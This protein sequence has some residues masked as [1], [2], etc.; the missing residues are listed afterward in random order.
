MEHYAELAA[1][2]EETSFLLSRLCASNEWAEAFKRFSKQKKSVEMLLFSNQLD[3]PPLA[4]AIERF[5]KVV[6]QTNVASGAMAQGLERERELFVDAIRDSIRRSELVPI[7]P[8]LLVSG[9]GAEKELAQLRAKVQLLEQDVYSVATRSWL[10]IVEASEL[11]AADPTGLSDPYCTIKN[12]K[13]VKGNKIETQVCPETL[14]PVWD[15]SFELDLSQKF[16]FNVEIFDWSKDR[17]PQ[18]L[19]Y[20]E[21][22]WS[23]WALGVRE[24]RRWLP[25]EDGSGT[26][27]I[28]L[29]AADFGEDKLEPH[30]MMECNCC[31]AFAKIEAFAC[32]VCTKAT[33]A[34][35]L[36]EKKCHRCSKNAGPDGC[37]RAKLLASHKRV[38]SQRGTI[39]ELVAKAK[40]HA[41][42]PDPKEWPIVRYTWP[43]W[44][45]DVA[46]LEGVA[47][48]Q[49]FSLTRSYVYE[50]PGKE[51][52]VSLE[53]LDPYE[54][55][56]HFTRHLIKVDVFIFI[57]ICEN[58]K[59]V[60]VV[61]ERLCEVTQTVLALVYSPE[62]VFRR[63][64]KVSASFDEKKKGGFPRPMSGMRKS[65]ADTM[66]TDNPHDVRAFLAESSFPGLAL[67]RVPWSAHQEL[68]ASLL[69][70][71]RN[72][73]DLRRR[74]GVLFVP[75]G[76]TDE[77]EMFKSS[78]TADLTEFLE[79]LG[80]RVPMLGWPKYAGGL[81]IKEDS[82]G[83][84]SVYTQFLG[85]EI[86]FHVNCLLLDDGSE[87]QLARKRYIGN[88]LVVFIFMENPND[89]FDPAVITSQMCHVFIVIRKTS[90][91][92]EPTKY[93]INV[94]A[95][96]GVPSFSPDLPAPNIL[97]KG[98]ACRNFLLAKA[99]N[100]NR[101]TFRAKTF[102]QKTRKTRQD[103]L[104]RMHKDL[105]TDGALQEPPTPVAD[106]TA[107]ALSTENRLFKTKVEH[108]SE[109]TGQLNFGQNEQI[110]A[111]SANPE[112]GFWT[113][114]LRDKIGRFPAEKVEPLDNKK[115]K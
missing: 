33:C 100:G 79:M 34:L 24:E 84:H 102:S 23:E 63:S 38:A 55:Y 22:N 113:G 53:M 8:L 66:R 62:G 16:R 13:D 67:N 54:T 71:E 48:E 49:G 92:D 106:L 2:M 60:V 81:N 89:V 78:E 11:G 17:I 45:S 26:V 36:W 44:T 108:T 21:I 70:F 90:V 112:E 94:V 5:G 87:Q 97:L 10:R 35:C 52:Y 32:E 91:G 85:F 64:L 56:D 40:L 42:M 98:E 20:V 77:N 6:S 72:H 57:G 110:F 73:T 61:I 107:L 104:S 69:Q 82:T 41:L 83:T 58:K 12:V 29:R 37:K 115:K 7:Q 39:A 14:N 76:E 3:A 31:K 4:L 75:S 25:V 28:G 9:S 95:K 18:Y 50:A 15:E 101:A 86:M 46:T 96:Q 59:P 103:L 74:I 47:R 1:S 111:L 109:V 43:P 19:G 88:D 99:L 93:R 27:Y 105:M 51:P 114:L 30:S 65:S 80:E 68:V